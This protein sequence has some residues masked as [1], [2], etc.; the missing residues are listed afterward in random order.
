MPV[1]VFSFYSQQVDNLKSNLLEKLED[2]L[3][4]LQNEPTQVYISEIF[5]QPNSFHLVSGRTVE[6]P[7]TRIGL[8]CVVYIVTNRA[9]LVYCDDALTV[10]C[11][12]FVFVAPIV[13]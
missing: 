10:T 1:L 12:L 11:S 5:E 4:N 2:C 9:Q 3:L 8:A 6:V 7:Q 13:C